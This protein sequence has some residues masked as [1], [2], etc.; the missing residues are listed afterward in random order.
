MTARVTRYRVHGL[1]PTAPKFSGSWVQSRFRLLS[2][3]GGAPVPQIPSPS[4]YSAS[5]LI[6]P[7]LPQPRVARC[8]LLVSEMHSSWFRLHHL[9]RFAFPSRPQQQ[10]TRS[11]DPN[12]LSL[13]Y[14]DPSRRNGERRDP[15]QGRFLRSFRV[16]D[17]GWL[18]HIRRVANLQPGF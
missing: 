6:T 14:L 12:V 10:V 3:T 17:N 16:C 8:L 15:T 5:R 18:G 7:P 4:A 9:L 2:N 13:A 11:A 1:G